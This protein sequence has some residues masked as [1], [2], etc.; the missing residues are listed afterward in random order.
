MHAFVVL[1]L[2]ASVVLAQPLSSTAS[3][4]RRDIADSDAGASS[5]PADGAQLQR[6]VSREQE[7]RDAPGAPTNYNRHYV[8]SRLPGPEF[9]RMTRGAPK[10][11]LSK[12]AQRLAQK[13]QKAKDRLFDKI[14]AAKRTAQA[15]KY[16]SEHYLPEH[17]KYAAWINEYDQL[18]RNG[19]KQVDAKHRADMEVIAKKEAAEIQM[20]REKQKAREEKKALAG[21]N[22]AADKCGTGKEPSCFGSLF[23]HH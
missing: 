9:Q 22:A 23:G 4:E 15:S 13:N 14:M 5:R 21:K 6:R 17:P 12:S 19:N 2:M 16:N 11:L 1:V 7:D 8:D 3:F 10:V 18:A 20:V